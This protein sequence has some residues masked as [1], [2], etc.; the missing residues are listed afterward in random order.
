MSVAQR[1]CGDD[2][3]RDWLDVQ[4]RLLYMPGRLTVGECYLIAEVLRESGYGAEL[5]G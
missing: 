5:F 2:A 1:V 3:G 4:K